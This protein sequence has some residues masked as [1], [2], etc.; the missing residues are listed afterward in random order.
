MLLQCERHTHS[1]YRA[2]GSGLEYNIH[3][4]QAVGPCF[5]SRGIMCAELYRYNY[6]DHMFLYYY[7]I[8]CRKWDCHEFNKECITNRVKSL[9]DFV[10]RSSRQQQFSTIISQ[11]LP[12]DVR[13]CFAFS[14]VIK[15]WVL[16]SAVYSV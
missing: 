2:N 13:F 4:F 1:V 6:I 7:V 11:I 5:V 8:K 9:L 15:C 14:L 10:R 16:S 3:L 12:S